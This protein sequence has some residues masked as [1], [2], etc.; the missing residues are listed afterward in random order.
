VRFSDELNQF[1]DQS[2]LITGATGFVGS[3]LVHFLSAQ[4]PAMELRLAVRQ[5][6]DDSHF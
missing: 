1:N 4:F 5:K 6:P 3:R 2:I